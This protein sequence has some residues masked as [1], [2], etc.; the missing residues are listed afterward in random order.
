MVL[1]ESLACGTP[2]VASAHSGTGEIVRNPEI[3][4]TVDLR[5]RADLMST[6]RADQLAEAILH[7][8]DLSRRPETAGR[9]REWSS[10]WSLERVG[11]QTERVLSQIVIEHKQRR[12]TAGRPRR[13][14]AEVA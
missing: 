10:Q 7:G 8:I 13:Q 2:V 14:P 5:D 3:G 12:G 1:T 9:C 6:A 4:A 11:A